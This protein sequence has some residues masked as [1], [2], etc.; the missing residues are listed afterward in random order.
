[1]PAM[2]PLSVEEYLERSIGTGTAKHQLGILV[3]IEKYLER[4]IGLDAQ[5]IG[6]DAVADA[7]KRRMA[8]INAASDRDYLQ[9]LSSARDE[10]HALLEMIVVPETWF[11]RDREPFLLLA[12]HAAA[13]LVRPSSLAPLR[14][15]SL[16]C[17]SGEEPYSIAMSL[18][19]AGFRPG[20]YEIDA[21]DISESLLNKARFGAYGPNSFR[22]GIPENCDCYFSNEGSARVVRPEPRLGIR[23]IRGNAMEMDG[24]G[25][26]MT[27]DMIFCRNLLIYQTE[28]A[29]RRIVAAL[30]RRMKPDALLFVGHAEMIRLLSERHEPVRPG[31]AFAYRMRSEQ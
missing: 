3:S 9:M 28:E 25:L 31:G 26:A 1:M 6:M 13:R 17:S 8:A 10:L 4:S 24:L 20:H 2:T 30:H 22:G 12:R 19:S 15:L 23:F 16:P 11:F 27:Y 29:R 7:V 21:V 5:A 18:M 14:I